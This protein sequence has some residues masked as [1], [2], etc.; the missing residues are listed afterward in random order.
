VARRKAFDAHFEESANFSQGIKKIYTLA[1]IIGP[2]KL[3]HCRWPVI[4]FAVGILLKV[5]FLQYRPSV[6]SRG[7]TQTRSNGHVQSLE[8]QLLAFKSLFSFFNVLNPRELV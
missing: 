2:Q 3:F 4:Y 8:L 5:K 6:P 1:L 7:S